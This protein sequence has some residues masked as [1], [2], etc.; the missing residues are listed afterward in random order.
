MY[1]YFTCLDCKVYL[2]LGK[3]VIRDDKPSYFHI[4]S[5]LEPRNAAR[6]ELN[7]VLWKMLADHA[8]HNLRVAIQGDETF[9][10]IREDE[11]FVRIGG[12][13]DIDIS[14]EEYLKDW[15]G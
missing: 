11:T 7:R 1:G 12:D 8:E 2:F 6:P 10:R 4:G 14:F 5:A 9:E 15:P 3:S 13:T